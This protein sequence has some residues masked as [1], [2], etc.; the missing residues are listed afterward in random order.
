MRLSAALIALLAAS[1]VW[2]AS[3]PGQGTWETT[4]VAR[5]M[6]NDSVVDAYY[7]TVL[8]ITWLADANYAQTRGYDADGL[9]NL[10]A[11]NQWIDSLN[12]AN[13]LG[14]SL[15][16]LPG[17]V[18]EGGLDCFSFSGS[19][20]G[21]NVTTDDSELASLY[22]ITL[23]NLSAVAPDRTT[24]CDVG[25]GAS[26][27][28]TNSGPFQNVM[29]DF[30]SSPYWAVSSAFAYQFAFESGYQDTAHPNNDQYVWVVM[31]GDIAASVV[32]VPAAAWLFG[33]ALAGLA[34]IRR[35]RAGVARL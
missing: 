26:D 4:L 32:P 16:R 30:P 5:D 29:G 14:T 23:A 22:F 11:A 35:Y 7:D 21:W 25:F 20:C 2:A 28:F 8:D 19:D 24:N 17:V 15:W 10:S 18:G 34:G 9:M 27:C 13:H 12:N 6:N 3:V 1:P 31:D 33:S